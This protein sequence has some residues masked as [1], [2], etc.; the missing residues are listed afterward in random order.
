MRALQLRRFA[1][2][3]TRRDPLCTCLLLMAI[4]AL[5]NCARLFGDVETRLKMTFQS[6]RK[7]HSLTRRIRTPFSK[8]PLLFF[9]YENVFRKKGKTISIQTDPSRTTSSNAS[10]SHAQTT[11][12]I[13][14]RIHH[15]HQDGVE[16]NASSLCPWSPS[17]LKNARVTIQEV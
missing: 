3:P 1:E 11:K 9:H 2:V 16:S 17:W 8:T 14:P 10:F 7:N 4:F 6:P 12:P 15:E 13:K 5:K